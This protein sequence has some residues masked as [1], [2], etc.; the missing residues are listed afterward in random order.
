M[1][2]GLLGLWM[3]DLKEKERVTDPRLRIIIHFFQSP[4]SP[5]SPNPI[6]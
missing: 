1:K 5:I 2:A 4:L 3:T 6:I